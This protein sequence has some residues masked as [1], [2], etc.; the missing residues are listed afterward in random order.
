MFFYPI[1]RKAFRIKPQV[2][3][4]PQ[5]SFITSLQ[6]YIF[7]L[8]NNTGVIIFQKKLPI[9]PAISSTRGIVL[10]Y[11]LLAPTGLIVM[12]MRAKG[13]ISY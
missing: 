13:T 3:N 8:N 6:S 11:S 1:I 4:T 7:F 2:F 12:T 5:P 10:Y 9:V